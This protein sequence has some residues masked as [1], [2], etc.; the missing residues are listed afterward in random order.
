VCYNTC[1]TASD[2]VCQDGGPGDANFNNVSGNATYLT[3]TLTQG[4]DGY[5]AG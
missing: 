2:E 5:Y 3:P 1:G 4:V